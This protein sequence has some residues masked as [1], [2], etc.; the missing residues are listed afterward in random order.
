MDDSTEELIVGTIILSTG[1]KDFNPSTSPEFGYG[2][3]PNIISAM[4]FER[5]INPSGPTSG[6]VLL[7]DGRKPESVAVVH[8]VGSRDKNTNK[9]C[10][11]AC[12][13]YSLKFSQLVT[14]Y[15]D[16]QVYEIFRDM[17]TF[18]KDYEELYNRTKKKGVVFYHGQVSEIIPKN[19]GIQVRW[20]KNYYNQPNKVIV[21]LVILSTGLEPH[22]DSQQI[23]NILGIPI[24]SDGFFLE[25][26]PKLGPVETTSNGIFLAGACQSPKDIPDSVIQAGAAAAAAI[27]LIDQESIAL[28]PSIAYV[29]QNSCNSCGQC[30]KSCPYRAITKT[31][32][33][34]IVDDYICKG[35]GTCVASCP[36]KAISLFHYQDQQLINEIIGALA[37]V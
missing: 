32:G 31:N 11:R 9:Y 21:D 34:Y 4:E 19:G 33:F 17:R 22:H 7:K 28:D 8:C 29:D 1:F 36:N 5:M 24:G 6:K 18:G 26:H 16:A 37:V 25:K 2:S 27:S 12:C 35:C 13:M 30:N 14:E 3:T 10:S 15:L 23:A 20:S